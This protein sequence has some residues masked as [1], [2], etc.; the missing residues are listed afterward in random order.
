MCLGAHK[1]ELLS[2]G[3]ARAATTYGLEDFSSEE[4]G[5]AASIPKELPLADYFSELAHRARERTR[6]DGSFSRGWLVEQIMEFSHGSREHAE[7]V[8]DVLL[9]DGYMMEKPR[10]DYIWIV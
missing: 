10:G 9:K 7:A 8:F 4:Q 6:T 2:A 5:K 3:T 1:E